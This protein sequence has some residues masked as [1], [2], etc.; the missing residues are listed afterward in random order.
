MQTA[1]H[2]LAMYADGKSHYFRR[3]DAVEGS[4]FGG[5]L[6]HAV[7]GSPFGPAG[8]QQVASLD[9]S[10]PPFVNASIKSVSSLPLVYGFQF[11]GCVIDYRFDADEIEILQIAPDKSAADW[12]YPDYPA[13]LPCIPIIAD[14]P[15]P[16]DWLAFS[17][18]LPLFHEKPPAEMVVVVPPA[19]QIG[20]SLWGKE[21]DAEGVCIVFEC[22]LARR[23]IRAYNVCG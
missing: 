4:V 18:Q 11:D 13:A 19:F 12:P 8:L 3:G 1:E 15:I 23:T 5:S 10:S 9:L 6:R 21:G 2:L 17:S 22:D 20:Q 14:A 16:Q 7:T